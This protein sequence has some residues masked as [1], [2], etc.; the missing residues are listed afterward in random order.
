MV[1]ISQLAVNMLK[2]SE[3]VKII[4]KFVCSMFVSL[5]KTD[6]LKYFHCKKEGT[7]KKKKNTL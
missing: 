5:C 1:H 7:K 2:D 4:W 3:I 6:L